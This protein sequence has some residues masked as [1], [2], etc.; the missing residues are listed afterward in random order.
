VLYHHIQA[1]NTLDYSVKNE[2]KLPDGREFVYGVKMDGTVP[3]PLVFEV[4]H[5]SKDELPHFVSMIIPVFSDLLV[6]TIRAAGVENFQVFPAVLRNPAVGTDWDGYWVFHEIGLIAAANLEKSEADT[7][8]EGDPGGV[9]TPLM[10]FHELVLDKKKTR[11]ALMF[12]LAESPDILLIHDRVMSHIDA[13]RP[14]NGWRF[15]AT[16]IQSA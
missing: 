6:K 16:E 15:M 13:S 1:A 9:D 14:P 10:G 7:I 8:M 3:N 11:S 12:R 2:P 5:P 4:D